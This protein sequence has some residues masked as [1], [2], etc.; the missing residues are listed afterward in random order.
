[1]MYFDLK[2]NSTVIIAPEIV[3]FHELNYEYR[4]NC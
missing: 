4:L 2:Y 3:V 1:M